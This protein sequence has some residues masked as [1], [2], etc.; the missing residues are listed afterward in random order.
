MLAMSSRY[1]DTII[2]FFCWAAFILAGIYAYHRRHPRRTAF[3]VAAW[4][5]DAT[6][7]KWWFFHGV[8][9]ILGR[10][11]SGKLIRIPDYCHL[12]LIGGS[13]SGKGRSIILPTLLDHGGSIIC[14]DV[15]GDLFKISAEHRAKQGCRIIRLAPFAAEGA[16][17]WNVLC[18]I[19]LKDPLLIDKAGAMASA[20][21]IRDGET[22]PFWNDRATALI[23]AVLV[24]ILLSTNRRIRCLN[25]LMTIISDPMRLA[26]VGEFLCN[27]NLGRIANNLGNVV[28]SLFEVKEVHDGE[29]NRVKHTALTKEGAGCQVTALRHLDW[30]NSE[31]VARSLESS[32]WEVESIFEQ[33]TTLYMEIPPSFLESHRGLLRLWTSTLI[34]EINALGDENKHKVLMLLDEAS[35]LSGLPAIEEALVRGRSSGVRMLLAYQSNLYFPRTA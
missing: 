9:L 28:K 27:P 2:G 3:G 22:E 12:L 29:G 1:D 16:D 24:I 23:K 30:L 21:V 6:L 20:L 33:G 13:G 26:A 17:S 10:T 11:L 8:G 4:A 32:T 15:K 7:K 5:T 35:A 25:S 34:R 31:P 19:K 14:N 18:T